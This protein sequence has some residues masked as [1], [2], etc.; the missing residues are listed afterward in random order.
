MRIWL[1]RDLRRPLPCS[2]AAVIVAAPLYR[3]DALKSAGVAHRPLRPRRR[4]PLPRKLG[5]LDAARLRPD[6]RAADRRPQVAEPRA[7]RASELPRNSAKERRGARLSAAGR[8]EDRRSGARRRG[9][10]PRSKPWRRRSPRSR[11]PGT[12]P[13]ARPRPARRAA[14]EP[15]PVPAPV[16][17]P[18]AVAYRKGDVA[19]LARPGK[20]RDRPG[21]APRP[22]VG[23]AA[24]RSASDLR[25]ALRL[26]RRASGLAGRGGYI[27][28]RRG[29]GAPRPCSRPGRRGRGLLRG[30]AAAVERRARSRYARALG[31]SGKTG[32]GDRE[33]FAGLWRDG[34][35]DSWTETAILREFGPRPDP[36]GSQI[37]RR[38]AAL[39]RELG[40]RLSRRRARR[41]RRD[42]ARRRAARGRARAAAR[43]RSIR[44]RSGFAEER[45]RAPVRAGPG[46]APLGPRLRRGDAARARPDGPDDASIN[47]DRWWSERRMVARQLLDLNEP[48]LAFDLCAGAAKPGRLGQR[49]RPRVPRRLDRAALPR[50]RARGCR[51]LRARRG[52]RRDAAVDRARRILAR[53]RGRG[54]RRQPRRRR[55]TTKARRPSRSPITA[56]SPPS[57]SAGQRL[58]LR[59]AD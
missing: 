30:R 22:R 1:R 57:A 6:R 52:R 53:P 58:A 12:L 46:R 54:D 29:G 3:A 33:S 27:R 26:R 13:R 48:K 5:T 15:T 44:A 8:L 19:G 17:P 36:G 28:Y 10:Q 59:V 31:A 16:I 49:S 23:G 18:A 37:S 39:R 11:S 41:P 21:P 7:A 34:N 51:A 50:R 35:F 2:A 32:R 25:G 40:R 24:G 20:R 38:P 9:R 4:K 45:P 56:S 47:P 42:E 55:S 43:P 14:A